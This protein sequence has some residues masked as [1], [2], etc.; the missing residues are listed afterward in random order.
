[1]PCDHHHHHGQEPS[2]KGEEEHWAKWGW[3]VVLVTGRRGS[4]L[5]SEPRD[6]PPAQVEGQSRPEG[7]AQRRRDQQ[8]EDAVG[9]ARGT[10]TEAR[11]RQAAR[12]RREARADE[13]QPRFLHLGV[14]E[15]QEYIR[16]TVIIIVEDPAK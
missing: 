6:Q 5:L 12:R 2:P 11:A 10:G 7:L 3:L 16:G 8:R 4:G 1:M 14:L 9:R 13:R 15:Q